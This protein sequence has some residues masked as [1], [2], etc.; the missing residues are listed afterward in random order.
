MEK[1]ADLSNEFLY[2]VNQATS[3]VHGEAVAAIAYN[4]LRL[5]S[6]M[7]IIKTH[8]IIIIMPCARYNFCCCCSFAYM[9][10]NLINA[11]PMCNCLQVCIGCSLHTKSVHCAVSLPRKSR[12]LCIVV[13]TQASINHY[14]I[15]ICL[16]CYGRWVGLSCWNNGKSW[17]TNENKWIASRCEFRAIVFVFVSKGQLA[18]LLVYSAPLKF[19]WQNITKHFNL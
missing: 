15:T 14:L 8:I 5:I 7:N 13:K 4:L 10:S 9:K 3:R 1:C 12:L 6:T 11:K 19:I 18:M 16:Y 17:W 2:R